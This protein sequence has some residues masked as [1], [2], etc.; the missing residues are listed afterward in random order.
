MA[1]L[2]PAILDIMQEDIERNPDSELW[3]RVAY[4]RINPEPE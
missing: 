4:P 1:S 2:A 3:G